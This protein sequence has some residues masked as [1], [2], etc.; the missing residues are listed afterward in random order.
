[1]V[2]FTG[3]L[4][5][6]DMVVAEIAQNRI[7]PVMQSRMP[8]YLAHGGPLENWLEGRA[9]D[10]HR[11]NSRI[12][13]K[14][15]RLTDTS[16]AAAVLHAHAATITDDYWLRPCDEPALCYSQVRFVENHFAE[17]A[18]RGSFDSY[19]KD[20]TPEQLRSRTPELT[21][22]GSF[23][24]CW[25]LEDGAWWMHKR[26]AAEERFSELF[27]CALGKRLGFSMAEYLPDGDH[28]KTVDFTGGRWNYEPAAALVGDEEDY[29]Y[30]YR[31]I[32]SLAPGL[33]RQYLDLLYMDALCFNVD[34]HTYNYG[35]LRD[36]E[37]GAVLSMAPNF[38]N[39]IA[40]ISRGY[41][42]DPHRTNG[43]LIELFAELL[44]Q[45]NLS[46]SPPAL[47]EETVR[48]LA[49]DILSEEEIDRT[50]VAEMILGRYARLDASI[51]RLAPSQDVQLPSL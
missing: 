18:L 2:S 28:I 31:R 9:I 41:T 43:L 13:K 5:S 44:E 8:L 42:D 23:E 20:F 12:L 40:L 14:I 36:R 7:T 3:Q 4:M 47:G 26:G 29:G 6:G 33:G 38:D 17:L 32:V 24:K 27:I 16:D 48:T 1:M 22:T 45:E 15:L 34:R 37:S 46:Y 35:F 49:R 50:F 21:N 51:P 25:R 19:G 30:N 11:P 10:R 39:N